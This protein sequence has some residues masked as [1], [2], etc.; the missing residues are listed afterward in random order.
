MLVTR[1]LTTILYLQIFIIAIGI[2]NHQKFHSFNNNSNSSGAFIL[3]I[4][5]RQALK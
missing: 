4:D 3:Y 1:K 5:H 2:L